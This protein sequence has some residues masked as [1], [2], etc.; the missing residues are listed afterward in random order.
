PWAT[1]LIRL[2]QRNRY[3][4]RRRT[5]IAFRRRAQ[6]VRRSRPLLVDRAPRH[7]RLLRHLLR[8]PEPT[9]RSQPPGARVRPRA[10]DHDA[11]TAPRNFPRAD[12]PE[13][14]VALPPAHPVRELLLRLVPLPRHDLRGR[15]PLPA[16]LRRLPALSQH[17]RD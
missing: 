1:D 2:S 16:V 15:V 17:A 12:H 13:L 5:D 4:Y 10:P 9:R 8:D 14:G 6:A 7:P 11:G 3:E